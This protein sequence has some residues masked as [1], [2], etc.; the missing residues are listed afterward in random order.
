[1]H[2]LSLSSSRIANSDLLARAVNSCLIDE[3]GLTTDYWYD[4]LFGTDIRT[5][6]ESKIEPVTAN[7]IFG[8]SNG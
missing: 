8:E 1:M 4:T 2:V 6:V 3:T 7:G 5:S